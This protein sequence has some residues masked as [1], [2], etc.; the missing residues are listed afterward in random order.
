MVGKSLVKSIIKGS[1][2][3]IV[4]AF[5]AA[6]AVEYWHAYSLTEKTQENRLNQQ[7]ALLSQSLENLLWALDDNS[8]RLVGDAY[9]AGTDSVRLIILSSHT[10]T[11]VYAMDK[12]TLA[13]TLYGRKDIIHNKKVIG[14]IEIG[15]SGESS[16]AS[17]LRLMI[18]SF[19][20]ACFLILSLSFVVRILVMKRLAQP[21]ATLGDWTDRVASGGYDAEP[22]PIELAELSSLAD[23]FYNMSEKI[24][25]RENELVKF[26]D[27]LQTLVDIKTRELKDAHSELLQRERLATL[28][29]LTATVSHELRNP[30][31]TIKNALFA[32]DHS[33]EKNEAYR[34]K[35]LLE[36]AERSIKRCVNIIEDL[37]DYARVK[38][39]NCTET[40]VDEWLQS[41]LAE[42]DMP[43]EIDCELEL[44]CNVR[45]S[46]DVERL[47][48]VVV[49]LVSN[50]IDALQDERSQGKQLRIFT[51][52]IGDNYEIGVSENGCGMSEEVRAKIFEPLFSTKGFGVGLGLVIVKNIVAQHHGRIHVESKELAGS[53]IVVQLPLDPPN[54]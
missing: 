18:Y 11:P 50:A 16:E 2:G 15:L 6:L 37:N 39:L 8:I 10:D 52:C 28:G 41:V 13:D 42:I 14:S 33:L 35:R 3:L 38:R 26:R 40:N 27:Q 29:E 51:R 22:P 47:R 32:I 54:E 20:L 21:L 24:Q 4:C 12:P 49:N 31:G 48:Q 19:V 25:G 46:F 7:L 1:T 53:R 34:V 44:S 17:L 23:K 36:L 45:A 9:M 5:L 43:S 30:L